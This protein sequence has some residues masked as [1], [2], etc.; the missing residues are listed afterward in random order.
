MDK[1]VALATAQELLAALSGCQE[2]I[3]VVRSGLE[4]S[5][6]ILNAVKC[7]RLGIRP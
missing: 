5:N 6:A 2:K 7:D 3:E 1:K 4:M